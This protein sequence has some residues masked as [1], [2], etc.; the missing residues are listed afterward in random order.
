LDRAL[1]IL[2]GVAERS[3][4]GMLS[5]MEADSDLDAVRKDPRFGVMLDKARDRLS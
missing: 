2:E 3:T 1:S 4:P 5:W